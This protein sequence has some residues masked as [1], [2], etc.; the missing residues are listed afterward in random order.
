MIS[1]P[2]SL[3]PGYVARIAGVFDAIGLRPTV[4]EE[5]VHQETALGFVAADLGVT[6]LPESVQQLVPSSIAEL[7]LT[8]YPTT[9]LIAARA[10]RPDRA[11]L[12]GAFVQCL[13]DVVADLKAKFAA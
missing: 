12:S 1:Y 9:Q 2:R 4:I 6:I 11:M 10:V 5:V 7:P 3:M 13:R 8:G